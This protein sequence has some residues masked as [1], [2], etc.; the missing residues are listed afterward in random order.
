MTA[1]LFLF[2]PNEPKRLD[3]SSF[4]FFFFFLSFDDASFDFVLDG[5]IAS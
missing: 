5:F 3:S 2:Y 1:F 4:P